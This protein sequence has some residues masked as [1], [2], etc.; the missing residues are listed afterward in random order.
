MRETDRTCTRPLAAPG[1]P[2]DPAAVR[3]LVAGARVVLLGEG[4]HGIDDFAR[5]GDGLFRTLA[6]EFGFTAFVRESGFAEGLAV[7]AWIHGG[8]GE[9]EDVARAGITYGFGES[10]AVRRQL[11]WLRAENARRRGSGRAPLHFWGMDLPGSSTSPGTA[12]RACLERIPAHEGDDE[13]RRL[14]DLGGRTEA[15]IAWHGLDDAARGRIRDGITGLCARVESDGDDIA[16]R[17]AATLGA[18][19]A[20]LSWDGAPGAYPR[21][22]LMADTVSWI[23]DRE[24]R[25]LVLAHNAHVRREPLHGRPALG[26]ILQERLGDALRVIGMT[27]GHGPVVSFAE[28]SPRP[29][30]WEA[31]LSERE[32]APGSLE[33]ALDPLGDVLVDL[34]GAPSALWDGL[35]GTH[36][37]GGM[38]P[39]A[40]VTTA[41][42]AI[43]HRH[44]ASLVPGHLDRL[45]AEFGPGAP[46]VDA[47]PHGSAAAADSHVSAAA[48]ASARQDAE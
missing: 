10:D 45:R 24:E 39:L 25:I 20:E 7:D 4:A 23:A 46:A 28:R 40:D 48:V 30:D 17:A 41:F 37:G 34:R 32:P 9:V 22:Q 18:F 29:F 15:A 12:V 26:T 19:L 11:T 43:A 8:A 3:D 47:A 6:T 33:R 13:L 5:L 36:A 42:D 31:T 44:R 38:D 27:Y 14:T 21:E 2:W 1:D 16:R 35:E